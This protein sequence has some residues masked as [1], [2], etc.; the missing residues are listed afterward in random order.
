MSLVTMKKG[1][2]LFR[3]TPG[4]CDYYKHN[5][6]A[7]QARFNSN[8]EKFG[9][10]LSPNILISLGMCIELDKLMDLGI[11]MVEKNFTVNNTKY[12]DESGGFKQCGML[13]LRT[14]N[15]YY[16]DGSQK[17]TKDIYLLPDDHP[18]DGCEVFLTKDE[19]PNIML[20]KMYKFNP[21]KI[22]KTADL[23]TYME[24][25]NFSDDFSTYLKDG[26]FIPKR[27]D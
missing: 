7:P 5:S 4:L 16:A 26:I 24:D 13:P 20:M 3:I 21:E 1:E 9:M 12:S 17:E 22:K 6:L 8:T 19:L 25:N 27:C 10:Y 11:F 18:F 2:K 23:F 15:Y 14:N